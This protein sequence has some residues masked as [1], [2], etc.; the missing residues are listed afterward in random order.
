MSDVVENQAKSESSAAGEDGRGKR[1]RR[2][3]D[4]TVMDTE[5]GF[6]PQEA[7][8]ALP[9]TPAVE[10]N[11]SPSSDHGAGSDAQERPEPP[12]V[13]SRNALDPMELD[14]HDEFDLDVDDDD[15]TAMMDKVQLDDSKMKQL[16]NDRVRI[17]QPIPGDEEKWRSISPGQ[18]EKENGRWPTK[19]DY[20]ANMVLIRDENGMRMTKP[21]YYESLR[22]A[23][24]TAG[25]FQNAA[26][27]FSD[28]MDALGMSRELLPANHAAKGNEE[29]QKGRDLPN[30]LITGEDG[31]QTLHF[32]S[33]SAE[34]R[35]ASLSDLLTKHGRSNVEL[36]TENGHFG[37]IDAIERARRTDPNRLAYKAEQLFKSFEKS[38]L[39]SAYVRKEDGAWISAKQGKALPS[40]SSGKHEV[41][42]INP[43]TKALLTT[44]AVQNMLDN[45][46]E[47]FGKERV[48]EILKDAGLDP[49]KITRPQS[50]PDVLIR[51]NDEKFVPAKSFEKLSKQVPLTETFLKTDIYL[52]NYGKVYDS[53]GN[54]QH[55]PTGNYS[56]LAAR[57]RE[58]QREGL[59]R[60]PGEQY[61]ALYSSTPG[62][63]RAQLNMPPPAPAYQR[64]KTL[65][66]G[67]GQTPFTQSNSRE[68]SQMPPNRGTPPTELNT[69][70]GPILSSERQMHR[71]RSL[72]RG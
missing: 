52:A 42:L 50:R 24:K 67:R 39:A 36:R 54:A 55:G 29:R 11:R 17:V 40:T 14:G 34:L 71:P 69:R 30:I 57:E 47:A 8:A 10:S 25:E 60:S 38:E 65:V 61:A 46:S 23:C 18:F 2:D 33:T 37:T 59:S 15:L 66:S 26:K 21:Q 41:L 6:L 51:I 9:G 48:G 68:G 35:D 27:S 64:E 32:R 20:D 62:S 19:A 28:D 56:T 49:R 31:E 22:G 3:G 58:G 16:A 43:K 12:E 13:Q 1:R 44:N 7:T 45:K 63:Q 72:G 70:E 53:K 4:P 5:A